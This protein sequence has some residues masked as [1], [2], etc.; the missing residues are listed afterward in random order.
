M[1]CPRLRHRALRALRALLA[2]CLIFAAAPAQG[3]P[4]VAPEPEEA[5]VLAL[6]AKEL[7]AYATLCFKNGFP[8]RAREVWF[9]VIGEYDGDDAAARKELGYIRHGTVWQLDAA[10]GYPEQDAPDAGAAK[11][12]QKRFDGVCKKLGDA[13][14]ALAD[15]LRAAGKEARAGYHVQRALR[16]LPADSKVVAASGLQQYEGITG[17]AVDLEILRR[18]R[19]MDRE[20]TSQTEQSYEVAATDARQPAIDKGGMPYTGQKSPHYTVYGDWEP[21]VLAQAATWAERALAF[22]EVAFA[23]HLQP[24]SRSRQYRTFCF[25]RTKATFVRLVEANVS[26]IGRSQAEFIV[27][28]AKATLIGDMHTAGV[29]ETET[30]YDLAV[31]WVVQDYVGL[32][33]DAMNEGIGHAVVG[34]FF[35]RNLVFSVGQEK[36]QHTVA[37][38]TVAKL[39][40]PDMD[41]WMELATEIAW[42]KTSTP[43]ARLPLLKAASF[44]TDG[45]IK[46]W[47]F[48]DYLL[49][50]DPKLLR[51]LD[52]TGAKARNDSDV[53]VAFQQ[54]AELP[55][56]QLEEGWRRFW[57]EDSAIKRAIR[58]K[59][60]P[61]ESASK[62]APKW[63]AAFNK[64]RVENG[65]KEV[66]WS[67]QL[68]VDCKEHVDYLKA[69]KD[70]RGPD[71]E[72]SQLPGKPGF[73]N[74]GRS[75][76]QTAVVW[77]EGKD[78]KKAMAEWMLIPGYRDAIL[79]RNIDTV[80]IYAERGIVV[81]D[82]RR[83]RE[84]SQ[85][86]MSLTYPSADLKGGR[87]KE[88]VPSA[89]DVDL[90]GPEVQKLLGLNKRG[91]QKQIGLPL[92]AHFYFSRA[93]DVKCE[94]TSRGQPVEGW[95]VR[96]SG[97]C[98]RTS[99]PGLW[100]FYPAEP[101]DK[102]V[103]MNAEWTW[104][105]GGHKVTFTTN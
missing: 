84:A 9:E 2:S 53:E 52:K 77:T 59:S 83:G 35:G 61:L 66:G 97:S 78:P 40:L 26:T 18:S 86:A 92:T 72:H 81:L 58:D 1:R 21:D 62:E 73:S 63:L 87:K 14:R 36:Q 50:R 79:N 25:V 27:E 44:P 80:G 22:C 64:A 43:A 11:M 93:D 101:L 96:G 10:F 94:V 76:A 37:S 47:S 31:R 105:D 99:V 71:K 7:D 48:C 20:I 39:L 51:L 68:S 33:S 4:V 65:G 42:S 5:A 75:F 67:A 56:Y 60:T 104:P 15:Q 6:G 74:S 23:D 13:H 88:P 95:L 57:T 3:K 70:Q 34:M 69:N 89:V 98:G 49:R 102:G 30:V 41:T 24:V 32:G 29:E 100:V 38:R 28:H 91:K 45:R 8:K 55:L 54:A 103:D 12:L 46:S 16:F 19:V 82:G 90:L 17:N 85:S